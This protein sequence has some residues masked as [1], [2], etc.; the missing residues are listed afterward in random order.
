MNHSTLRTP[1]LLL[2]AACVWAAGA[3]AAEKPAPAV[4]LDE[5]LRHPGDYSQI[6][7]ARSSSFPAPIPAFRSIMHGEAGFSTSKLAVIKKNRAKLLPAIAAK[8]ESVD[9]L[10]KPQPQPPD[11]SIPKDQQDVDPIGVDPASFNTLLL[12]MIEELDAVE[13]LPQLMTLEEKFHTLLVAAEKDP[14]APL[15]QT[16]GS[17]GVGIHA[18]NLLKEGEEYDKLTPER[19][20]EVERK[21]NVFRAQAVH[22]DILA[23]FVRL[24][25]KPG[26]QPMM[27]SSLEKTYGKLLKAKW[28]GDEQLSKYK[29]GDDIPAEEK[30]S[31]KFDPIH[32]V[33]YMTWDPVELPYSE[34]TRKQ[35]LELTRSFVASKKKKA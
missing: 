2:S 19:E 5:L 21:G 13:V 34:E 24:M 9:L 7:D 32:K 30:D 16:D 17:E 26:Y 4:N 35:I 8:L 12:A 25:R 20:A 1:A 3:L 28:S 15:P 11:P 31:I 23:I 29:S 14:K 10:R 27:D 22:R 33:A 6:C 18:G